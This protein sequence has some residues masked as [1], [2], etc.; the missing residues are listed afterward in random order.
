[1]EAKGFAFKYLPFES[2]IA[3]KHLPFERLNIDEDTANII[4]L[5]KIFR[6]YRK[7]SFN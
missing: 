4:I 5:A 2:L 1:M 3:F 7:K 6:N